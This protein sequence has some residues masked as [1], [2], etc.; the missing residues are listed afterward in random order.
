M[1]RKEHLMR[2]ISAI[3]LL[4]PALVV[5]ASAVVGQTSVVN[6]ASFDAS[7]PMAPGAFATVFGQNLCGQTAVAPVSAEGLY[8]T[9][10]GGCS[11]SING[12]NVMIQFAGPGQMN[13]VVP[14][15]PGSGTASMV[16]NSGTQLITGSMTVGTAGPGVFSLDGMGTGNGAMLHSTLW[17]TG[18]FSTTTNGQTTPVS[19]FM[20]G[21][22]PSMLPVVTAGGMAMEVTFAGNTPGYPGLQQ[23]N[24]KLPAG[25]AGAGRVPVMVTSNGQT[26]NVTYM[27]VLPTSAMMQGMPGWG[28]GT[29]VGENMRRGAE[30]SALALN[31][32]NNTALVADEA[33]DLLRVISLSSKTTLA[34]IALPNGSQAGSV[35]VNSSGTLA[36]AALME[37]GSIAL[38]D[39]TQNQVI[40]VIG[41]GYYASRLAFA[42]TS[43]LVTNAASSSVA[44]IDTNARQI[45]RTISVGFGASGIAVAGNLAVVANM[46]SGSISMINLTDYSVTN[47]SLP[48]GSRPMEVAISSTANKA[49]ITNPM[50]NNAFILSLDTRQVKQVDLA[51]WSGM[52]LGGAVTNGSLAFITNQMASTVAVMDL[53]TGSIVKTFTVDPGPRSLAVNPGTNRLLV[54]C[55]GTGTLDLVDLSTYA[56]TDRIN[57]ASGNTNGNWTIPAITSIT[58]TTAK[59]GSTFT[60]TVSG[61]NFQGVTDVVFRAAGPGMGGMSMGGGGMATGDDPSIKVS[62]VKVNAA[63]TQITA[64]VQILATATVGT[65]QIRLGTD[66]GDMMGPA[67]STL[68]T[69][70]R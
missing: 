43:L 50:W 19:I 22:D 13:F 16:I 20:T 23:I 29:A 47:V 66:H 48:A 21:L 9:T 38:I 53:S 26:S 8:P 17:Q 12:T 70:T 40:S 31:A 67:N 35:A 64:S 34:T 54:L 57:A 65:R 1:A 56:V 61:A 28:S 27:N 45:S 25:M 58:P 63:A 14:Q 11:L 7:G 69:V 59:I 6:A 46:Q 4:L 32:V 33:A 42:G 68:F 49:L 2:T 39:L 52:G 51:A 36:A 3:H 62:S 37:Q 55:Q 5:S 41:T 15:T 10:L 30:M 44:V 18:P 24:M 60:L